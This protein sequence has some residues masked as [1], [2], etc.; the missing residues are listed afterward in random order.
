MT[1]RRAENDDDDDEDEDDYEGVRYKL[2]LYC[3][4]IQPEIGGA[5]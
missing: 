1:A 5:E 3:R 4:S 2:S